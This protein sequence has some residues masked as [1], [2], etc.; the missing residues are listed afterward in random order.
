M[1]LRGSYSLE[2]KSLGCPAVPSPVSGPR[3]AAVPTQSYDGQSISPA[4]VLRGRTVTEFG[5][6][7]GHGGFIWS[8]EASHPSF[9]EIDHGLG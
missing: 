3:R 8:I 4:Q 6:P 9:L 2:G 5:A 1:A 7:S